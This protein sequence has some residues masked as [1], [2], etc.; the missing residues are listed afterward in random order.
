MEEKILVFYKDNKIVA[1]LEYVIILILVF[2]TALT[3]LLKNVINS[4]NSILENLSLIFTVLTILAI[5][6]LMIVNFFRFE[7]LNGVLTSSLILDDEKITIADK[8]YNIVD[9]DKIE[10]YSEDIKGRFINSTFTYRPHLSQGVK[11]F[12]KLH[13]KSG[14]KEYCYF[15]QT[16]K[17]K[18]RQYKKELTFYYLNNKLGWLELLDTLELTDYNEIQKFKKSLPPTMASIHSR[19]KPSTQG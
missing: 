13:M 17:A 6:I 14:E 19:A 3:F 11:N 9:I 2:L 8:I 18:I 1:R 7:Y 4:D 12:I 5:A 15:Q 16:T 10:I